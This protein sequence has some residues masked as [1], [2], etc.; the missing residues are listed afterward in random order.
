M[1]REGTCRP[2]CFLPRKLQVGMFECDDFDVISST[3]AKQRVSIALC[4]FVSWWEPKTAIACTKDSHTQYQAT[5]RP[6]SCSRTSLMLQRCSRTSQERR[7]QLCSYL[8]DP[9]QLTAVCS[10]I[11]VYVISYLTA[12]LPGQGAC[13]TPSPLCNPSANLLLGFALGSL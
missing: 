8:R 4:N 11:S 1:S 6:T 13:G 10:S 3:S 9:F 12:C 7:V 2:M 5:P